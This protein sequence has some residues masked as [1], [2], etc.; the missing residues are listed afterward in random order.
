MAGWSW[1]A[2]LKNEQSTMYLNRTKGLGLGLT[3]QSHFEL[4]EQPQRK[5][6]ISRP[7]WQALLHLAQQAL[8]RQVM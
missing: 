4:L 1:A 7:V 2:T 3:K 8:L 5:F 6:A